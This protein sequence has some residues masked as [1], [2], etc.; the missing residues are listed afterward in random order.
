MITFSDE[1]SYILENDRVLLRPL[2]T[3]DIE[4][5]STFSIYE[6][7]LW[8]Y[9]LIRANGLENLR[10][11][12]KMALQGKA[13]G[14]EYPFIVYDKLVGKYAG[15][16]RF[17]DIQPI[18]KTLQ[19]GYTWYGKEFQGTGLNRN[20]K[21]LLLSFVFDQLGYERVEFR[22]DSANERSIRA[23]KSIGCKVEGILRSTSFRPDGSRRDS[24]VLS[25]LREEWSNGIK[26]MLRDKCA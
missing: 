22:A 7:E 18:H 3:D 21:Y 20:C 4:H 23:M 8:K 13:A 12:I 15:S 11:Y 10:S 14:K 25:I 16:T 17:Y 19:L 1:H 9:S 2:A 5:L 6:P 26:E 24:I